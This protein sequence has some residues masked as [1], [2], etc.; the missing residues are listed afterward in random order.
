LCDEYTHRY[1]KV[2][3][4]DAKLSEILQFEPTNISNKGFTVMPQAMPDY[5][6]DEDSVTAY[7]K[8][9]ILEKN[10]FNNYTNRERPSWLKEN[11]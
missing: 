6:K 8:Y 4:T 1:G 2:H 7:R 3:A 5:C 11:I 9:Y 10:K